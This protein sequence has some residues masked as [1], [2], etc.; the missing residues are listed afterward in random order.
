MKSF[1]FSAIVLDYTHADVHGSETDFS[2][3]AVQC[4]SNYT[5]ADGYGMF[6]K[7]D[8]D[9]IV[10]IN[11]KREPPERRLSHSISRYRFKSYLCGGF[12]SENQSGGV[13]NY[14]L[15]PF[16]YGFFFIYRSCRLVN[17]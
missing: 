1:Q 12:I 14:F 17:L 5:H 9:Q 7:F 13:I 3:G 16:N 15:R 8:T 11:E 6:V 4:C 10:T 2:R